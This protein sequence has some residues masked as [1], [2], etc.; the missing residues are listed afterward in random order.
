MTMALAR[1]LTYAVSAPIASPRKGKG[2]IPAEALRY[3]SEGVALGQLGKHQ[4][5]LAAYDEALRHREDFPEAWYNRGVTL[6]QLAKHQEAL[7]AFD[8]ALRYREDFPEAW[9]NR[10]VT[11][12][13]LG[14]HQEAL[15]AFDEALGY[16]KDY[17]E[18][19]YNRGVALWEL[20]KHQEALLAFDEA[21]GYRKDYPE[22]W[23]N[24]GVALGLM[25]KHQ[26]ALAAFGRAY[27]FRDRLADGGANLYR[28]WALDSLA[29]ALDGLLNQNIRAFEEGGLKYIDI[30]EKSQRDGPDFVGVVEDTLAQLK[31]RLKKRK[32]QKAF[33]ELEVF[34]RLMKI[35][36]PFEGWK[37]LGKEIS[38]VWPKGHSVRKAVREM[39]R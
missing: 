36:D 1:P 37:A 13:Q 24:K 11:L 17:P 29:H 3:F 10:G 26:E 20:G 5:E 22:A 27:E 31:A 2:K 6:G 39:R 33:E 19:W 38:K 21:L 7:A 14:K 18:A 15:A 23:C 28:L 4:E 32:E 9:Y 16:R 8:E 35:K 12:G 34:I 25:G 30:F